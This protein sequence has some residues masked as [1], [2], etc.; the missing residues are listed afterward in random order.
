[1]GK[2]VKTPK[3]TRREQAAETR[4][5]VIHAAI[6]VFAEAGYVG[7]RMTDI[8]GRAGVAVQTVY[9]VFHTKAELLQACFD[10]AVLGPDRLPPLQQAFFA[11]IS[12]AESGRAA[13]AAFVRG[14]TAILTRVAVIKEVAES[15]SHE[16]DAVAV[17]ERSEQLRRDGLRQ[18]VDQ[19]AGRW[20]LR[21]GLDAADAVDLLLMLSTSGPFLELRRYGWSDTKY[22]EWLTDALAR[23]LLG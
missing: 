11:E 14:N 2:P 8:A 12:A 10:H 15:A 18:V 6:E 23:E 13:L 21:P 3:R 22:A 16:P 20:G 17:V 4:E 1:M 5:R 7:A 19:I 9:F